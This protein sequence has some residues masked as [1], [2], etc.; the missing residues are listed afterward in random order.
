L[1][2]T[3]RGPRP[4]QQKRKYIPTWPRKTTAA[5]KEE[6]TESQDYFYPPPRKPIER[7]PSKT[8]IDL[9][10]PLTEEEIDL[11]IESEDEDTYSFL[12][13]IGSEDEES[14][15]LCLKD[16]S[17]A[18][19]E[20]E[21][22][23][24]TVEDST[25]SEDEQ[26]ILTSIPQISA[27]DEILS[28]RN[29][30]RNK[31]Q[32]PP[33]PQISAPGYDNDDETPVIPQLSFPGCDDDDEE[34][35]QVQEHKESIYDTL[36]FTVRCGGCHKPLSGQAITTSGN[37]WHTRCFKC[38]TCKQPLEH[39]AFYEKDGLPYCALD[40]HES[41]SPRCDYCQTPIEEHSISA[42][43]KTYHPGH[44]FC[45]EC[46]KPF[47]QSSNFLEHDGH[48]YCERDYYK[49]FGKKCLGCEE[50]ITGE[51]LMALGGEWHKECFVCAECGTTFNSTFL[52]SHG[53]PY[54]DLHYPSLPE[55]PIKKKQVPALPEL[56]L[57]A[58][59]TVKTCHRCH[60]PI[61]GRC[62]SAFGKYY[63][64][65]HFQCSECQKILSARVTGLYQ[66]KGLG[67]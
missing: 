27:P 24:I 32:L 4:L 34:E 30:Q 65:L 20:A 31:P 66:D 25:D 2:S 50:T 6:K 67:E 41:F 29:T 42:L 23:R 58:N 61:L 59:S 39:I 28:S 56:P 40:F 1:K 54:C 52:I 19:R 35:E 51:F 7:K 10:E 62:S 36:F 33:I 21:L 47:D 22:L 13:E 9:N 38:Q 15:D 26:H 46:G 44:F 8:E 60:E 17:S 63:H 57:Q 43:G 53:K 3:L 64:P 49:R 18:N 12:K 16:L 14:L 11:R 55:K 45:R 37:Q 5:V 48:A